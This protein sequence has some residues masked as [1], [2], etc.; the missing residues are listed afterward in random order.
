MANIKGLFDKGGKTAPGV[1]EAP[2]K[3]G[4]GSKME[5]K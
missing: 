4:S 3:K 5:F 1:G 2:L